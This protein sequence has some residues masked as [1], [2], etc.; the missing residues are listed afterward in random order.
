M[1]PGRRRRGSPRARAALPRRAGS[2]AQHDGGRRDL[3]DPP[4]TIR[5][6]HRFPRS[7]VVQGSLL[8][9]SV[10]RLGCRDAGR[11]L[12]RRSRCRL[13]AEPPSR[14]PTETQV[15]PGAQGT[16]DAGLLT[17]AGPAGLVPRARLQCRKEPETSVSCF[18]YPLRV[19]RP[20]STGRAWPSYPHGAGTGT[21]YRPST[22]VIRVRC[23]GSWKPVSR[24]T[25]PA[26][27]HLERRPFS[28][29]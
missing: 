28:K 9:R 5:S 27:A 15:S 10:G 1:L 18:R 29:T 12:N 17:I 23:P 25:A 6:P 20:G 7:T 22:A 14:P 26:S 2:C 24:S 3:P 4:G 13:P 21:G 19:T 8:L 11:S 16:G